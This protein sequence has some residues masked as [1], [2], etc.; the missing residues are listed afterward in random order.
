MDRIGVGERAGTGLPL[1]AGHE[2][3]PP[4][5]PHWWYCR[6]AVRGQMPDALVVGTAQQI[7]P[8]SLYT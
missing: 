3:S 7:Q 6:S 2:G 1:G 5:H 4:S 8:V